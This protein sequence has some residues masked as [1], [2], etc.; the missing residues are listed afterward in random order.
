MSL[1]GFLNDYTVPKPNRSKAMPFAIMYRG[2]NSVV[3][4]EKL[5]SLKEYCTFSIF[6]NKKKNMRSF[7]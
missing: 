6:T 4:F 2:I 3:S 1:K 7:F 5:F